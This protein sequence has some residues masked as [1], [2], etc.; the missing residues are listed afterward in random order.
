VKPEGSQ[1]KKSR[2]VDGEPLENCLHESNE[3]GTAPGAGNV[4][5]KGKG[6]R[7]FYA[8]LLRSPSG[9]VTETGEEKER[10][11]GNGYTS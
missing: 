5:F 11:G 9:A 2:Y 7:P 4:R 3:V 8:P 1:A 6:R 10:R